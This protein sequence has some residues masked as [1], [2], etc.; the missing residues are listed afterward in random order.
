MTTL[1]YLTDE[2]GQKTDVVIPITVWRGL[3]PEALNSVNDELE[4]NLEWEEIE[5][6]DDGDE[7]ERIEANPVMH[8]RLMDAMARM[9]RGEPGIPYEV[10]REALGI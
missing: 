6:N 8:K 9:K 1:R 7:T 4:N 3:F 2:T 10:V 5:S